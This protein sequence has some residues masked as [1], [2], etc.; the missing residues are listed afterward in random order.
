M[1]VSFLISTVIHLAVFLLLLWWG[2]IFPPTMAVEETYYVD[3]VNLPVANPRAGSPTQKGNDAEAP[4]PPPAPETPLSMPSPPQPNLKGRTATSGK[5]E[6]NDKHETSN[7]A[8][9]AERMAKLENKAASQQEEATL[10]RL[11][12]K[13]RTT[14]SGRAGMPAGSGSEAGSDYTAYVQSRLK[15]AF[16]QTITYTSKNPEVA[17]HLYIDTDGKV[18]RQKIEKSSGDRTFELAVLR[19]IEKAGDKLVPPPNHRVFEG[20]F[21][22]KPQGIS[23]NKP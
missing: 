23:R 9:F 8:A 21:L 14:G 15:D 7:D 3:V 17:V 18:V 2:R 19:A 12:K 6:K 22:F 11:R 1:G 20:S 13:L 10:E 4:P 5:T 16:Y